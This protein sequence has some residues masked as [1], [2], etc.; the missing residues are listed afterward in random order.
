MRSGLVKGKTF[1]SNEDY[2]RYLARQNRIITGYIVIGFLTTV[3]TLLVEFSEEIKKFII[4][5]DY[6]LGV[7]EGA[8]VALLVVGLIKL[9]RNFRILRDEE[10]LAE[11][12]REFGDERIQEISKTAMKF[13]A[14]VMITGMYMFSLIGGFFYP[15]L[16][17]VL[18]I[19]V[20]IFLVLYVI[21][22][23]VLE[24]RM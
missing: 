9:I 12:R 23:R 24:K 14:W 6:I 17:K 3:I 22:Y 20:C 13:A 15:A 10:E 4:I 1:K 21:S 19:V 11:R 16:A 8:G 5:D 18:L 7:Y 2:R